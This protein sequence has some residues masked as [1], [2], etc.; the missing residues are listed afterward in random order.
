MLEMLVFLV[1]LVTA[2]L[3]A[4]VVFVVRLS[5][6]VRRGGARSLATGILTAWR[7]GVRRPVWP[8]LIAAVV[9]ASLLT[10]GLERLYLATVTNG[11]R[12]GFDVALL[13]SV[14]GLLGSIG[15]AALAGMAAATVA[16]ARGFG[17]GTVAGLLGLVAI[18]AGT[19]AAHLPLRAAYMAD[20]GSFPVVPNLG[21]G[22]LLVPFDGFFGV[23]IWA[24]PWPLLA[25]ALARTETT[26]RQ[27]VRDIWQLL[28]ELATADLPDSRSA[29]GTALRAE[30]AAIDPPA[31]RRRFA[32]GGVWTALR[33]GWPRGVWLHATGVALAVA[34]GSFAASRWSLAHS[35]GGVL[36]FWM[37]FPALLIF[38]V[39]FGTA[40]RTRSFSSGLRTALV[41]GFAAMAAALA[42][43]I[44][45]AMLWAS[46]RAGYLTTGDAIPPTW[47]AAVRDVVRPEFLAGLV[48]FWTMGA[49]SGAALGKALARLH[50]HA[51][52]EV[53]T[54]SI[55]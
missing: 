31:E 44:P 54:A 46:E 53:T 42:V 10:V 25:A 3:L 18:A 49:V 9:G 34:G 7:N 15:C 19:A 28:L 50:G 4:M 32:L 33:S 13:A 11:P 21:E 30:L 45:E 2:P 20:P 26:G 22:G 12:W 40:W 55:H 5:D 8:L 14:L 29:W 37:A 41:A 17:A 36:A 48:A 6:A 16:R 24:L 27:G 43:G 52:P 23:L 1:V 51:A 35:R 47:Q 38:A 39:A